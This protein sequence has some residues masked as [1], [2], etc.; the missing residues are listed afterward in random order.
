MNYRIPLKE[1]Q[2]FISVRIIYA[3]ANT[4]QIVLNTWYSADMNMSEAIC[5]RS[6]G[7]GW[8]HYSPSP[9]LCH[10]IEGM[11]TSWRCFIRV[12]MGLLTVFY[13]NRRAGRRSKVS[14]GREQDVLLWRW[15][16]SKGNLHAHIRGRALIYFSC[17]WFNCVTTVWCL[18]LAL[19]LNT[20]RQV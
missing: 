17:I 5:S 16:Q 15:T 3:K 18:C 1:F 10:C 20:M 8:P 2:I 19:K 6:L 7:W 9:S 12:V 11:L 14:E 13:R 4:I